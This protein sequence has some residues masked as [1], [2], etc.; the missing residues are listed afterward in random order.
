MFQPVLV[1]K[2]L[3]DRG[4]P[5]PGVTTVDR[6]GLDVRVTT[7]ER[8]LVDVL[9]RPDLGGGWEEVWRSLE[10]VP[11][12]DLNEVVDYALLLGNATTVG[13]VGFF[14]EQHREPLHVSDEHLRPLQAHAPSGP[15]SIRR[16]AGGSNVFLP[17]W[18]L[19]VPRAIVDRTWEEVT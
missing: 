12:V 16:G 10:S 15:H 5:D 3:R 18:N 11:F 7:L 2:S 13:K 1:S 4:E 14:L 8:T 6:S 19:V 17:T 9:D